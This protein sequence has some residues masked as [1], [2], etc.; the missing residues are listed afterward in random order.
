MTGSWYL[1]G[2]ISKVAAQNEYLHEK[3]LGWM[4][5][6]KDMEGVAHYHPQVAYTEI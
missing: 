3:L 1:G 2:S 4:G 6:V 5:V